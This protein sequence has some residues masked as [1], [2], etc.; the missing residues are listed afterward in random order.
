[1]IILL[2]SVVTS[3]AQE[4]AKPVRRSSEKVIIGGKVY[5][6]HVVKKGQTL[7]SISRAYN[8]PEKEISR[9]NPILITGL[10]EGMVLKIPFVPETAGSSEQTQTQT[11]DTG[12][13]IYH[14]FKK[15]ETLYSLSHTYNVKVKDIVEAN[16]GIT[17]DNISIG[18]MVKIP[19]E[20][21]VPERIE[22]ASQNKGYT[23]H[24]VAPGETLYSLAKRYN[25]TVRDIRQA[26]AGLQNTLHPGQELQI[27]QAVKNNVPPGETP[28]TLSVP[29]YRETY[30][31]CDSIQPVPTK[32]EWNVA[33]LL[34]LYLIEN[35][36]SSY[37]DSSR[38]DPST[39]KK[40]KKVIYRK[41]DWIYPPT[42]KFLPFYQGAM[43]ALDTLGKEGVKTNVTVFDTEQDPAVVDSVV[44]SGTLD[45]MDLIIGPVY[46]VNVA[47]VANYAGKLHIPVVSPLSRKDDFLSF[48]PFTF[49]CH[50]S[51][52]T[53]EI[54]VVQYLARNL[55]KN[56]VIIHTEDS[57]KQKEFDWVKGHLLEA[58]SQFA[59]PEI[60]GVKEVVVPRVISPS[61]TM[62]NIRLSLDKYRDNLVWVFSDREGFVSEVVS[63]LNTI[64]SKGYP[65]ELVGCSAWT[66]FKNIELDYFVNMNLHI[67]SSRFVNFSGEK[68]K[69]FIRKYRKKYFT[70]PSELDYA[71]DG[72]DITAYFL[73]ALYRYGKSFPDCTGNYHPD[74]CIGHFRFERTGWFSGFMNRSFALIQYNPDYS[75][76]VVPFPAPA[77]DTLK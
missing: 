53:E 72:Y 40:I 17:P 36:E 46:P 8:V 12:H 67:F 29:V 4:P 39:R 1:M 71:W 73:S 13:Y 64:N 20:S 41:P 14:K 9:E 27:P 44:R 34:P 69:V 45:T 74:L 26:N 65:L 57:V 56:I 77:N 21:V 22:F 38:F 15:G 30:V 63:R 11:Q 43:I 35:D 58:I 62:N 32:T 6:I 42:K 16:P 48:N 68:E 10:Q 49:E 55:D 75:V 52:K 50:P 51:K 19:R 28:D 31:S 7:Y 61:D 54:Q 33:V 5:Y 70:D 18:M 60:I 24:T 76:T 2:L 59:H 47:I 23:V 37:I 3:T 25:V 66:Y